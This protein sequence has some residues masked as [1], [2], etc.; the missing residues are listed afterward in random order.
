MKTNIELLLEDM[1]FSSTYVFLEVGK[2]DAELEAIGQKRGLQL[3]SKDLAVFKT[4]YAFVN[5]E[6]KNGCTLPLAEVDASLPT[7]VGKAIDLDHF[8]KRTIGTWIDIL[9]NDKEIIAYGTIWK[10]NFMEEFD[11]IKRLMEEGKLKVSFEAW[12]DRI[13]SN[14]A[15]TSYDLTNIEWAGGAL[16]LTTQPAFSNAKVLEMAK[17]MTSPKTFVYERGAHIKEMKLEESKYHFQ[18]YE[19]IAKLLHETSCPSCQKEDT[20]S[21]SV[22]DFEQSKV[23]AK[24]VGCEK[25][26]DVDL[27]EDAK[28]V[29]NGKQIKSISLIENK[30]GQKMALENAKTI[31]CD[32]C[33]NTIRVL[34]GGIDPDY[35]GARM[36]PGDETCPIC[37]KS[38]K[39]IDKSSKDGK[40][41]G[42]NEIMDELLKKYGKANAEELI[43]FLETELSTVQASIT[44]KD[45]EI[46]KLK[47]DIDAVTKASEE[48]KGKVDEL[49]KEVEEAR[50]IEAE[51]KE[52]EKATL[53]KTRREQLGDFAKDMKDEDIVDD[54]KFENATLK[55]QIAE[56]DPEK[57]SLELGSKDKKVEKTIYETQGRIASKAFRK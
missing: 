2:D 42:G 45:S 9:R 16:L 25:G 13:Y 44:A 15:K 8:R 19:N 6:N 55:K 21:I 26:F 27:G 12:G 29:R 28:T 49:T 46:T 51:K 17:E 35:K 18:D 5:E 7:L 32:H 41:R 34:P 30:G 39:N 23:R 54:L 52:A 3:P 36:L 4:I 10:N 33:S 22:I 48:S 40:K 20:F 24:C 37:D 43:K 57:A 47:T 56:K 50:K 53:I 14:S 38:I 11:E 1:T 31:V